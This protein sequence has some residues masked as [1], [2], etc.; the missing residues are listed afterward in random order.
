[1]LGPVSAR[2]EQT[3]NKD[4]ADAQRALATALRGR[5]YLA[6][7]TELQ[8]WSVDPPL[9]G[10]HARPARRVESYLRRASRKLDRRLAEAERLPDHDP[11]RNDAFHRAR[12]AAKRARY[13]AELARPVLGKPALTSLKTAKKLQSELGHRQ[14]AVVGAAFLRRLGAV[15]G[16]TPGENGF[17]FGVLLAH[18]T[19]RG[20]LDR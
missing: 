4:L 1:M 8:A 2:L 17:T 20:H 10:A 5:R 12:K 11:R 7:L 16:T 15:A 3:L 13:T 6:L 18:E 14:D 19:R 9:T